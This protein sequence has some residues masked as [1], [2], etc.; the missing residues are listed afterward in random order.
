MKILRFSLF[1]LCSILF[2]NAQAQDSKSLS[3]LCETLGGQFKHFD[4]GVNAGT[5]GIGL[6]VS[7]NIGDYVRLRTGF[8]YMPRIEL[9][10]TFGVQVGE[11]SPKAEYDPETGKRTDRLGR[12]IEYMHDLT[13]MDIDENVDMLYKPTFY[14]T[15]FLVDVYPFTNKKWHL[16]AGF[17][18]GTKEIGRAINS[19]ADARTLAGVSM[20]NYIYDKVIEGNPN[21][22]GDLVSITPDVLDKISPKFKNAGRMGVNVGTY[23]H[24]IYGQVPVLD[25][26]GYPM[27]DDDDNPMYENGIIHAKGSYYL[28]TPDPTDGAV[29]CYAYTNR[30]KPYVG[31]GYSGAISK[32]GLW[33]LDLDGGILFWGGSPNIYTHDGTNLTKDIENIGGKVGRYVDGVA[34]F[35]VFPVLEVRISRRIF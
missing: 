3:D 26:W 17:Y 20:Y 30:F 13:G 35:K 24:D 27:Y 7:T 22:F 34:A 32:D 1:A 15:K 19:I 23:T 25:E 6:D 28:L 29:K 4:V 10:S 12:M 9:T 2:V 5:S 11:E 8:T 14:N 16:T 33:N 31:F 21:I 18:W